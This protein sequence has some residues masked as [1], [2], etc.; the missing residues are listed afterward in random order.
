MAKI[1]GFVVLETGIAS[2]EAAWQWAAYWFHVGEA[3]N[4]PLVNDDFEW[5]E[6][7]EE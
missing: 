1:D 6:H 7:D 3:A 5:F 4:W 2:K